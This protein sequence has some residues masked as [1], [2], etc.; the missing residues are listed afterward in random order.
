M[1]NLY[2]VRR[3]EG[4]APIREP[5]TLSLRASDS[6]DKLVELEMIKSVN[7]SMMSPCMA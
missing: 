6:L 1:T 3:K 7:K 5:T 2:E 4:A